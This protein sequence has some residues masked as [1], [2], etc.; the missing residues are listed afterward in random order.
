MPRVRFALV[1]IAL[2][3]LLPLAAGAEACGTCLAGDADDSECCP[4]ACA[5][6][7][8]CGTAATELS[9]PP[10]VDRGL[11]P[12]LLAGEPADGRRASSDPRDVFHVPKPA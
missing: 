6:C 11:T 8:C 12:V 3:L 2:A 4:P 5:L 10:R 1:L 7:L 9:I